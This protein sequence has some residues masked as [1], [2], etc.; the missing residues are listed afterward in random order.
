MPAPLK[1]GLEVARAQLPSLVGQ[2]EAGLSSVITRHGR[3]C[4]AI[5]PLQDLQSS[6]RRGGLLTL[7]G[8]GSGLWPLSAAAHVQH[9]RDEWA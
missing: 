7:R 3:P 5:V 4:A 8:T 2:A 1:F 6:H 9:L